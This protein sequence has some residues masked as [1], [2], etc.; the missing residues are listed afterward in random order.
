MSSIIVPDSQQLYNGPMARLII[1]DWGRTLYDPD[2]KSL[3]SGAS[4]TLQI[5]KRKHL[6]AVVALASDGDIERRQRALKESGI[7][8]LFSLVLF[9]AEN[10]DALYKQALNDLQINP[11]EVVIVDDRVI[12]GVRWGNQNGAKTIWLR[13]GKF[14]E[15]LPDADTGEPTHTITDISELVGLLK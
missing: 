2:A 1:F 8:T 10:K 3:L 9:G 12:R 7:E 15:E 13:R 11:S 6:L 5:L 14:S 4:E